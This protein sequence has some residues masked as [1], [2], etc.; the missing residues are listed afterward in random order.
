[1]ANTDIELGGRISPEMIWHG[2]W[3]LGS[4]PT[5]AYKEAAKLEGRVV[6]VSMQRGEPH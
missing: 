3:P 5:G 1:M 2:R 6:L 4:T